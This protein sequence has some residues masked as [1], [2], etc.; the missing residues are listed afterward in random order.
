MR[1]GSNRRRR[2]NSFAFTLLCDPYEE[3]PRN[4]TLTKK[5]GG[6]GVPL[7]LASDPFA[8]MRD[9]AMINVP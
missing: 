1:L 6:C 3:L 8:I 9:R 2:Y 5:G 4:Q 7:H